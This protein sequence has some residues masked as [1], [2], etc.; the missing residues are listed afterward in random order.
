MIST[1]LAIQE[2][3][4]D[5]VV[6]ISTMLKAKQIY[7]NKDT[8]TENEFIEA[9]WEYSAH[10]SALCATLV[11]SAILTETQMSELNATIKEMESMGKDIE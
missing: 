11:T 7:R 8:M 1:A 2:A 4:G 6:D 9:M 10:L 3:T 5:A